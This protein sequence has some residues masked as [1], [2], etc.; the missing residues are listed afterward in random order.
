MKINFLQKK[1]FYIFEIDSFLS[2]E[3][4][5]LLEKNFPVED[6]SKMVNVIGNKTYFDNKMQANEHYEDLALKNNEAIKILSKK[7][8]EVFFINLIKKLKKEIFI[9]RLSNLKDLKLLF[10]LL[11]KTKIVSKTTTKN[12]FQKFFYS[13]YQYSFEFSY[14]NK[15]SFILPHTDK[16]SKLVSLMLYFPTKKLNNSY[17][18]TTFYNSKFKNFDNN[19]PFQTIEE[20]LAFYR[21]NLK[22]SLIFPFRKKKLFGFIKSDVSWHG[23]KKLEIPED[24][25]RKSINI[26]LKI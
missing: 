1:P 21:K 5:D 9:S 4:Y 8:D 13:N 2:D 22:E 18:G 23:V 11:R 10:K 15:D 6:K 20:N 17:I 19:Q 3:E 24:E 14:M 25:T 16:T 7:F 12:L 26:N